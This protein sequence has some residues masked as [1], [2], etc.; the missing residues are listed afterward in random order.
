MTEAMGLGQ[1]SQWRNTASLSITEAHDLAARLESRVRA[2]AASSRYVGSGKRAT[3][4]RVL[5]AP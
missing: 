3:R 2:E 4:Y 1:R 5:V